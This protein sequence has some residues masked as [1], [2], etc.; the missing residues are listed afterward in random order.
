MR[1]LDGTRPEASP[2]MHALGQD[3]DLER[4]AGHAA[5]RRRE[6]EL[7]VVAGARIQADHQR[8]VAQA[9]PQRVDVGQQ[10]VRARFLAGFDQAD[11]A[12]ML[13]LL[14]LERLHRGDAGVDGIAVVGAAAPVELAVLVLGR[15]GAEVAAPAGEFRLLV[16]VAVH[17]HGLRRRRPGRRDL[18]EQHRRAARQAHDLERQA[19]DLLRL[20]PGRRVAHHGFDVAVLHPVLVE[21]GRLGRNG[22]VLGQ[23]RDDVAVP[24]VG[25][26]GQAR[27]RRRA[28]RREFRDARVRSWRSGWR[29]NRHF[30]PAPGACA[31]VPIVTLLAQRQAT[32]TAATLGQL[33]R[34]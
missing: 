33:D 9:R 19:F 13:H 2:G 8:H 10:V 22:D 17:Q 1:K 5:Q 29:Q 7:V 26:V 27:R 18:E 14:R 21:A 28:C 20:D 32:P 24:L 34:P 25:G 3:L 23:L 12:R 31:K 15:P 4:A 6:P 16:Q 30:T 11:D